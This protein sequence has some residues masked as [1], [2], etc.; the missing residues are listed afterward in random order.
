MIMSVGHLCKA[1]DLEV[2]EE[3]FFYKRIKKKRKKKGKKNPRAVH[4]ETKERKT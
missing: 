2:L 3:A 1:L 4:H